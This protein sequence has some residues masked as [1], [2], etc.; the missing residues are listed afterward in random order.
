MEVDHIVYAGKRYVELSRDES[1]KFGDIIKRDF[2][3]C[4]ISEDSIDSLMEDIKVGK[5]LD[6]WNVQAVYRVVNHA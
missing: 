2:E 3:L 1:A 4:L 5:L 6:G